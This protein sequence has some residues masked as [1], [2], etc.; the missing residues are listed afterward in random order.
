MPHVAREGKGAL[1][2][3]VRIPL[4]QR[5]AKEA[6]RCEHAEG[7]LCEEAQ[8]IQRL[9]AE[10]HLVED[11]DR[12]FGDNRLARVGFDVGDETVCARAP[13]EQE[14]E[15]REVRLEVKIDVVAASNLATQELGSDV[16][17]PDTA[18][19]FDEQRLGSLGGEPLKDGLLDFSLHLEAFL[20]WP[21][22]KGKRCTLHF[23]EPKS[24]SNCI[25]WF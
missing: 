13:F 9:L 17:L 16:G 1:R 12:L 7:G 3:G 22:S 11:D 25:F 18:R 4:L 14:R 8:G 5:H 2:R 20:G 23:L 6:A 21:H 15:L 24:V 10:L 19:S